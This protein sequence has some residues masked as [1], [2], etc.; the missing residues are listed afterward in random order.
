MAGLQ[1]GQKLDKIWRNA[2]R[3]AVSE[4]IEDDKDSTGKKQKALHLLARKLVTT[5]MSGN[6]PAL[7]EIGDRLDGRPAQAIAIIGDPDSPVIF[8][9]RLGDG[10]HPKTIDSFPVQD[11]LAGPLV[12]ITAQSGES[13]PE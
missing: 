5:G 8:N 7:K 11:V 12:A 1:Q 9:L 4:R 13:Q 10:L 6:V 3:R 2:I